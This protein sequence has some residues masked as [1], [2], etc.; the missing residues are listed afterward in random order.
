MENPGIFHAGI[1]HF[2][3]IAAASAMDPFFCADGIKMRLFRREKFINREMQLFKQ[4]AWVAVGGSHTLMIRDTKIN[5][6]NEQLDFTHQADYG[7]QPNGNKYLFAAAVHNEI[8]KYFANAFGNRIDVGFPAAATAA[9]VFDV[10][11]FRSQANGVYHFNLR[12]GQVGLLPHLRVHFIKLKLGRKNAGIAF[13]T[14]QNH[15]LVKSCKPFHLR[16]TAQ[17]TEDVQRNFEEEL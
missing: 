14:K 7:K 5:D 10:Y 8:I 6:R 11:Y 16:R 1:F 12:F 15:F 3:L 13:G 9:V 4:L 17:A 2:K